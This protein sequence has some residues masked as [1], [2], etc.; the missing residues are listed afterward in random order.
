MFRNARILFVFV[1]ALLAMTASAE[2]IYKTFDDSMHAPSKF[3]SDPTYLFL[4]RIYEKNNPSVIKGSIN[5]IPKT[6]HQIWL[7]PRPIPEEYLENS[8]KWQ[9]LHPSWQ[10]K[11]WREAD[12]ESWNF[13]SK[14]LFNKASS[15]QEKADIL[16][17]EILQKHGGLY[18]DMDYKPLKSFDEVHCKYDFYGTIEPLHSEN[19]NLTIPNS[20]VASAPNNPIFYKTLQQIRSHWNE[21]EDIFKKAATKMEEKKLIHLAVNRSMMPFHKVVIE[22]LPI[23]EKSVIFPTS[24]MSIEER[25]SWLDKTKAFFGIIDSKLYFRIPKPETMAVQKRGSRK[26]SNLTNIKFKEP[27][28]KF[29]SSAD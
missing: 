3:Q 24:Y 19:Q 2:F 26:I 1:I 7:G 9:K 27:W 23:L 18:A 15:Y 20:I 12:I 6:I 11:L 29:F 17:Y 21:S 8:K 22:T 5:S 4:K 16:R 14:D 28:Y 10:Y 13:Q 25:D